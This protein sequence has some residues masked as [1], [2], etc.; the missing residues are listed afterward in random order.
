MTRQLGYVADESAMLEEILARAAGPVLVMGSRARHRQWPVPA[1]VRLTR[2]VVVPSGSAGGLAPAGRGW[3]ADAAIVQD[4]RGQLYERVGPHLRP[5]RG[6]VAGRA[7]IPRRAEPVADRDPAPPE[8]LDAEPPDAGG[9]GDDPAAAPVGVRKLVPEPGLR[10]VVRFADFKAILAAQMAHASRI[11]DTHLVSCQVHVYEIDA[12]QR[13]ESLAGTILGDPGRADQLRLLSQSLARVLDLIPLLPRRVRVPAHARRDPGLLLRGERIVFLQ[14]A[15]DPTADGVGAVAMSGASAGPG[16]P[17]DPGSTPVGRRTV[18][19]ERFLRPWEF[20]LSREE[21]LYDMGAAH[22]AGPIR[23]MLD[24]LGGQ[25]TR[26]RQLRRWQTLLQ[27]KTADEQLWEVRPPR[28]SLTHAAIRE[29]ARR[30]LAEAGYDS[31][32]LLPEWEI[33]WRRKGA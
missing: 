30:M 1:P 21:A 13:L 3:G 18:I 6:A 20:Q 11:R 29:W 33:F 25:A 22:A 23:R 8:E 10:R 2:I 26:R 31:G 28:G 14:L 27:G 15:D 12:P 17:G 24:W 32:R 19:P 4:E 9:D 7:E 5:L 16:Q